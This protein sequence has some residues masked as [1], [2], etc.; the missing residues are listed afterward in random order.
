MSAV[1]VLFP[2]AADAYGKLVIDHAA[3]YTGAISNFTGT[4]TQSDAIDLK[5]IA[6]DSGLSFTYHDNSGANT[7]GTLTISE[8][9]HAVDTITFA[10][11]DYTAAS[12]TL[13]SDGHGG[14]L[15]SDP[16]PS[17]T[18]SSASATLTTGIDTLTFDN[19]THVVSGTDQTVNNGD[20]LAGG[21]GANTLT[22]DS[23]NGN[24]NYTFG[25]GNHADIGLTNFE[26]LAL[27]DANATS[28]HAVTVTFDSSFHNNGT[29]TVDGSA[30]THL[31][32]TNLT[33]DAHLAT[34]DSFVIIGSASADTLV[35]GSNGN[36][37][38][39][40]GGGGDTLTG[41]G[42]NDT[43]VYKFTTDSQPGTGHFDTITNFTH[44]SDHFDFSAISGLNSTVQAVT[45]NSLTAAP[46]SL[47]AHTID[48]V[49]SGGNTVVYANASGATETLAHVDMEIHLNNV[50][51]VHS[52]DFILHA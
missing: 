47:A 25:D 11:G 26:K 8:S 4:S 45:F 44:N 36:N 52:T 23:G 41:N 19:G 20:T 17:A 10:N 31:N 1:A 6:F 48:I 2:T 18:T 14:T 38:I 16:P 32:G 7:G 51:N 34:S 50:T 27:T 13:L 29:L 39:T 37:T 21:T 12:F 9:G 22:I 49:T 5:D 43:F 33:V 24:H 3:S 30:L 46:D 42:A 35:G 28:D 15:I 40:G